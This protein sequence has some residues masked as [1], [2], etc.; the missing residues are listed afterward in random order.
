MHVAEAER[1]IGSRF[2]WIC[3]GMENEVKHGFGT[4]PNAEFVIDPE[5]KVVI[6][7]VWSDP[8]ELRADLEK[9]IGP[10]ENSTVVEDLDLP[11]IEPAGKV[12]RG[13][14]PR[15]EMPGWMQA[16]VLEPVDDGK[17][18]YYVKLRAEATPE[19]L[20]GEADTGQVYLGFHLDPLHH[21]HWNNNAPALEFELEAPEGIQTSPEKG[22][23][24]TVTEAADADPREFLVDVVASGDRA[25][26]ELS[27]RY[28]AC[29]DDNTFCIP[30]TQRYRIHLEGNRDGGSALGR[31]M[32]EEEAMTVEGM[33][34]NF[35]EMDRDSDG[36]ITRDELPGPFKSRFDMMD[37]NGDGF[38]DETEQQMAAERIVQ[39][40][41]G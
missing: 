29:D 15:V 40:V 1:V 16:M 14:V 36:R 8:I 17:Q 13:I 9:L 2:R 3:D 26:L 38:A 32:A 34:A 23:G 28:F 18:P 21:V 41:G 27:V 22:Q 7:R 39:M 20:E 35:K 19:F 10:A 4:A 33:L 6:R 30:V 24:P 25:P 5:G 37:S 12:A 11:E 31:K